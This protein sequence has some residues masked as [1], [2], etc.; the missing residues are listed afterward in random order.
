[1]AQNV[2]ETIDLILESSQSSQER[3][4]WHGQEWRIERAEYL[5]N[6]VIGGSTQP[7]RWGFSISAL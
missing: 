4:V 7:L 3:S 1:M 2:L 6:R 5:A